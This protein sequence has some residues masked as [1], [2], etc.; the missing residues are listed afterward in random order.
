MTVHEYNGC[1]TVIAYTKIPLLSEHGP[2]ATIV[3]DGCDASDC[4]EQ[5]IEIVNQKEW[6]K[7]YMFQNYEGNMMQQSLQVAQITS[8]DGAC[9]VDNTSSL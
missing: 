2:H 6:V 8:Q 4:C 9:F 1:I 3:T 7:S 5:D